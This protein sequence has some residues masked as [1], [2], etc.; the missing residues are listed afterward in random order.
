M[1][2]ILMQDKAYKNLPISKL[3][4]RPSCLKKKNYRL[5]Y[6]GSHLTSFRIVIRQSLCMVDVGDVW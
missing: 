5:S 3:S 4:L 1:D 6:L 2:L